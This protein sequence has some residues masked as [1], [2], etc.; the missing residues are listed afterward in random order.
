MK[1]NRDIQLAQVIEQELGLILLSA[2]DQ[3][4]NNLQI[5]RVVPQDGGKH[6]TIF[7]IPVPESEV[8]IDLE[9]IR[10]HLEKA[11]SYLKYQ[12]AQTLNLKKCPLFT[13]EPIL[14]DSN[15]IN[16]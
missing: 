13:F 14:S 16:S 15:L 11:K 6:F 7:L 12:L 8:P 4:I 1:H 5:S 3:V 2:D 10:H 9:N